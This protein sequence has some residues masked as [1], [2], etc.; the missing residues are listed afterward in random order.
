MHHAKPSRT[1]LR[2]ATRRAVHQIVDRPLVFEDPFAVPILG[3]DAA[4]I[5]EAL[6]RRQQITARPFRAFMAV[7]SRCAEDELARSYA[8]GVRQYVVL[9]AGLDTF[10]YRNPHPDLRVF[11]VDHPATQEW[12][13][14]QL[15]SASIPIPATLAF[16][17]V[18]FERQ[19]LSERLADAG[20]VATSPAFFSWLG[21]TPYL[22]DRAF[23][24]T[25]AF[26]ASLPA[27]SGVVFD[28][29]VARSTLN[30]MERIAL[31]K[32]AARVEAAGEPF[33]LFFDPAGLVKRMREAGFRE[34]QDLG[35]MELNVRYFA[36]RSDG[37]K[38]RGNLGR[39]LCARV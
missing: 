26:I 27:P 35:S 39:L 33:R 13:R 6:S 7:R 10:A 4:Y 19:K 18:D 8:S 28:Y 11:E 1:A 12:K 23:A 22:T 9:G 32:L 30:W 38:V 34:V 25:I 20:F 29:T 2:V 37:L 24:E 21:V 15:Q 14:S 17:P 3:T 36:G 16:A 5:T 31:D